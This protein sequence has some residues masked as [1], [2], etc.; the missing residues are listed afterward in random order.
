MCSSDLIDFEQIGVGD[1][2]M[3]NFTGNI[4]VEAGNIVEGAYSLS[5]AAI[6]DG[7]VFVNE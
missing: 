6:S 5:R 2:V 3:V 7:E 1:I 4:D